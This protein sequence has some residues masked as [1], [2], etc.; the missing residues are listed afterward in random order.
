MPFGELLE[1]HRVGVTLTTLHRERLAA[2]PVSGVVR[3]FSKRLIL[4]ELFGSGGRG[5]G[6][7]LIR[8]EDLTRLDTQ[9]QDL[10]RI[11]QAGGAVARSHPIAR[12]VDPTEWRT[13]IT[14]AQVVAPSLQLHREGVGAAVTLSSRSIK[15][16]K[17]LVV[18][19]RPD[20]HAADEGELAIALDHLTRIDFA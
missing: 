14:S 9:T 3:L 13:A 10:R 15:L 17:H 4:V 2:A 11:V 6:F 7:T 19:E 5:E 1:Q 16:L 20:P 18:G 8:R 12:E